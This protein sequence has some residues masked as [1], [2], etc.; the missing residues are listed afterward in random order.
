MSLVD[1]QLQ[2]GL[3]NIKKD[4]VLEMQLI[5]AK[6]EELPFM[7]NTFDGLINT[8]ALHCFPDTMKT[9]KEFSRVLKKGAPIVVQTFISGNA[10]LI[11]KM[12]KSKFKVFEISQLKKYLTNAGFTEFQYVLDGCLINFTAKK[13]I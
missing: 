7:D 1:Q 4:K 3:K 13:T 11:K 12:K 2:Q 6:G 10:L 5:R 8:G 9:L